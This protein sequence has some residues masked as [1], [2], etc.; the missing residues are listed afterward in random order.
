MEQI[1]LKEATLR[2][3]IWIIS[4]AIPF[5]VVLL[6][7]LPRIDLGIDTRFIPR[8]NALINS[9]VSVL[10]AVGYFLAR[11]RQIALHRKVMLTAFGLSTLF[12]V[13]YVLYHL[14]QEEVRFGGTGWLRAVYLFIL[15]SHIGLSVFIVPLALFAIYPALLGRYAQ[16]RRVAR[17]ALPL[18]LYVAVTGVLVY[19]FLAPY[20][21]Y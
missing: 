15:F 1:P 21:P 19:V 3:W 8:I 7:R 6:L 20:Y 14:T 13:L 2:R 17:W 10:L 11:R 16:H 5:T 12:L 9:S 4:I 18:W